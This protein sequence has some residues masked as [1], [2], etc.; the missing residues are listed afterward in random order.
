MMIAKTVV[1]LGVL[2]LPSA[3]GLLA[4]ESSD[5]PPWL[6]YGVLGLVIVALVVTKQ[7]VPG[8]IHQEIRNENKELKLEN[9]DLV[10]LVFDTQNATLPVLE[11]ATSA[12]E[13]AIRDRRERL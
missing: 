9:K 4:A 7:L 5:L 3:G 13:E 8:W 11:K 10:K 1:Y 6:Q 12:V 2:I